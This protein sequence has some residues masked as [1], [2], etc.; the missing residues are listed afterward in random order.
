M[1]NYDYEIATYE[2]DED[3]QNHFLQI[4]NTNDIMSDEVTVVLDEIYN[5]IKDESDWSKLLCLL[6]NRFFPIPMI[7]QDLALP[8]AYSFTFMERTHKC[9]QEYKK[10]NTTNLVKELIKKLEE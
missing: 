3:Y 7:T 10:H 2:S 8:I 9:V 4:F 6:A 1:Y 5:L